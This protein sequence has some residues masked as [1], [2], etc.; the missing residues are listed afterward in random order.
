MEI[1]NLISNSR[2]GDEAAFEQIVYM[3]EKYVYAIAY[4]YVHDIEDAKDIT[5]DTFIKVWR[6]L[7]NYRSECSFKTWI[8]R[9]CVSCSIDYLRKKKRNTEQSLTVDEDGEELEIADNSV[10]AD[11]EGTYIKLEEKEKLHKALERL[12]EDKRQILTMRY[13]AGLPYSEISEQLNIELGTVKSRINRAII[14]LK[15]IMEQGT[16]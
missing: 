3:Y 6:T 16:F 2:K 1:D 10:E 7:R 8:S 4:H 9:I 15:K 5:Q 12:D 13:I 11:L 14:L